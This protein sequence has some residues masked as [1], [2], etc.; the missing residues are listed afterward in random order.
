MLIIGT[1]ADMNRITGFDEEL[2]SDIMEVLKILDD[3]YGANRNCMRVGG[4]VGIVGTL[5]D[6]ENFLL[7]WKIDLKSEP[8]EFSKN[9]CGYVKKLFI[10][11]PDFAIIIYTKEELMK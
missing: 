2:R 3:N 10:T 11:N 7:H 6:F 8:F 1:Q 5:G 9:I 4:F